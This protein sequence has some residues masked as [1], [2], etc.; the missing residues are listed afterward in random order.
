MKPNEAA[1]EAFVAGWLVEH[2]GYDEVKGPVPARPSAFDPRS[3]IDTEDLFAFIG[4]TQ[5]DAWH[6]LLA[7]HGGDPDTAQ[8]KFVA[9]LAAELDQR[10]T[11]AVLRHGVI[12]HGVT[13]RLAFFKPAHGLT[14]E[15]GQRYA[16]N[17]L[18]VTRQLAYEPGSTKTI[19][20]GLF[21]NGL[22][23]ATAELK[24]QLTGQSVEDAIDAVPRRLATPNAPALARRAVV[25]FALDTE[26]VVMTTRLAGQATR[27]LPFNLGVDGGAGNPANPHGHRTAYLWERVWQRDAWLD[28]LARFVHSRTATER[29]EAA[30]AR[31]LPPPPPVGRGARLGAARPDPWRRPAV[32][33]GALGRVGEVEHHRLAG[34][35]SVVVA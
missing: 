6:R 13:I 14:P 1:F 2:G 19:D 28:L 33:G 15:L 9:R 35:P 25:H 17:R 4:A 16:A 8:A 12:D 26:R 22:L 23:V 20:L 7:L 27:F 32:S 11:L 21:V 24:N 31:D 29:L 30:G 10:G 34:P 3:G 18:N 5:A